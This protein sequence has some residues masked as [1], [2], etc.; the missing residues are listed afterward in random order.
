MRGGN[1]AYDNY[2]PGFDSTAYHAWTAADALKLAQL[3][4]LLND[5]QW[6]GVPQQQ[7]QPQSTQQQAAPINVNITAN[8]QGS[9]TPDNAVDELS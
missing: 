6:G 4:G 5:A 7:Q 8:L 1:S 3:G 2:D 9:I